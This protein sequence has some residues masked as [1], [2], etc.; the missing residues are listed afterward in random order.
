MYIYVLYI[1][2]V[3]FWC[4]INIIYKKIIYFNRD[5]FVINVFIW[6]KIYETYMTYISD[7]YAYTV[8]GDL[9]VHHIYTHVRHTW[10]YTLVT[11]H[12]IYAWVPTLVLLKESIVSMAWT[13]YF[14]LSIPQCN[15][16]ITTAWLYSRQWWLK[17]TMIQYV[18][19][20]ICLF[21]FSVLV[22]NAKHTCELISQLA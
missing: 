16:Q 2:C 11:Y 12:Q 20:R 13:L 9:Y 5:I 22:Q 6:K 14:L 4:Y 21:C 8:Y 17:I 15:E 7:V 3:M 1:Y 10:T 19:V 18:S